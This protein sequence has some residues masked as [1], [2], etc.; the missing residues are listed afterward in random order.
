[1]IGTVVGTALLLGASITFA[2][3]PAAVGTVAGQEDAAAPGAPAAT[4]LAASSIFEAPVRLKAGDDYIDVEIGHAAPYMYDIDGDGVRD[5]LVGQF[6][7]GRLRVYKNI[8]TTD[9]PKYDGFEY[10]K[11][12]H[13]YGTVPSG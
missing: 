6:G 2:D 9:S 13:E 3:D 4:A 12:G 10:L 8:G 7:Q 11:A 5:L 1:M